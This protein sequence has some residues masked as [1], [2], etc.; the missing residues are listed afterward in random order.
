MAKVWQELPDIVTISFRQERED[1]DY[2]SCLW[3]RFN[4]DK[5]NYSLSI[6]SDCGSY[7]YGWCPTPDHETF[8]HLCSRFDEFYLLDKIS[9]RTVVNGDATFK[10]LTETLKDY[11]DY[12]YE[13]LTAKQM[14]IIEESC[15]GN[16]NDSDAF[17]S[18]TDAFDGTLLEGSL[19]EYDIAC[20]IEMDY[21]RGAKKIV[22]VFRNYIQPE[23]RMLSGY[24]GAKMDGDG[25]EN[26]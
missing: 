22:E 6:E 21:P 18:I 7:S 15:Y 20:C 19:S 11:D 16:R 23:L 1:K 8:L 2:G 9:N 12:G 25:N 10:N 17:A 13:V 3:A 4:F 5:K 24:K 26:V 14:Q